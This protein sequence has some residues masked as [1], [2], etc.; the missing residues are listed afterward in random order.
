MRFLAL[1]A[2]IRISSVAK[3][4]FTLSANKDSAQNGL[5]RGNGFVL[6][7]GPEGYSGREEVRIQPGLHQGP[8]ADYFAGFADFFN[9][10]AVPLPN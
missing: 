6:A 2:F 9:R 10:S 1:S 7:N 4:L 8:V 5:L 3:L